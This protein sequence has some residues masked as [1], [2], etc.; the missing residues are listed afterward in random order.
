MFREW[1]DIHI[2]QLLGMSDTHF[3]DDHTEVVKNKANR[4]FFSDGSYHAKPNY[5]T[6]VGSSSLYTTIDD[7]AKWGV[8]MVN[9][10]TNDES[11]IGR[12]KQQGKLNNGEKIPYAFGISRGKYNG[13]DN[14][15]HTG[16]W[17]SFK[18][19]SG[20]FTQEKFSVVV[21]SND[22]SFNSTK[23][24]NKIVDVYAGDRSVA[25]KKGSVEEPR[26]KVE[27]SY[28]AST[29]LTEFVGRFYSEELYTEYELVIEAKK[30]YATHNRLPKIEIKPSAIDAFKGDVWF[31]QDLKFVRDSKGTVIGIEI[32][33][34][35]SRNLFFKKI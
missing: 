24:A 16:S 2:F 17:A 29:D 26:T 5:L 33:S 34:G 13:M 31:F 19:Y 28:D 6:A 7:F 20:Y 1:T 22:D 12:M 21:F 23:I 27:P 25:I 35:R 9:P 15:G 18:A 10:R 30:L 14:W 11:T 8:N 32:S 3:H 4:Y